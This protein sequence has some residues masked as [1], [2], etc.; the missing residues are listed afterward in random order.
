[1]SKHSSLNDCICLVF[2]CYANG[3]VGNSI[4]L[5]VRSRPFPYA[6]A[7]VT[8]TVYRVVA[9]S[10]FGKADVYRISQ[11]DRKSSSSN[12]RLEGVTFNNNIIVIKIDGIRKCIAK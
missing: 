10:C 6:Y 4:V 8:A 2:N 12:R 9:Y 5:N 1:M 11:K 7:F 3:T